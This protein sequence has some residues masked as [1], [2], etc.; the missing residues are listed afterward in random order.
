MT[1]RQTARRCLNYLPMVRNWWSTARASSV[2]ATACML[3][4]RGM[5]LGA[6]SH[7]LY[8]WP[9]ARR[10]FA[11]MAQRVVDPFKVLGVPPTATRAEASQ[12]FRVKAMECHPDLNQDSREATEQMQAL[13]AAWGSVKAILG[14]VDTPGQPAQAATRTTAAERQQQQQRSADRAATSQR[15]AEMAAAAKRMAAERM[16]AERMAAERK[17]AER[18]AVD[19]AKF[20]EAKAK[21][22][23][24]QEKRKRSKTERAEGAKVA[25]AKRVRGAQ[26][27]KDAKA[28]EVADAAEAT[29]RAEHA[30]NA[31]LLAREEAVLIANASD[32]VQAK[33][34]AKRGWLAYY[35]HVSITRRLRKGALSRPALSVERAIGLNLIEALE[36]DGDSTI[37]GLAVIGAIHNGWRFTVTG[38]ISP[39]IELLAR[40]GA[41]GAIFTCYASVRVLYNDLTNPP[42]KPR[43]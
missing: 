3:A 12:A 35:A 19:R 5:L 9:G 11:K 23:V 6:C 7:R 42:S 25:R 30:V 26:A 20:K 2:A 27:A 32:D 15:A 31:E 40:S 17:A 21:D 39:S 22:R 34:A 10:T 29:R 24:A 14:R 37:I 8:N 28:K 4:P 36:D 41:L 16:A 38:I 13:T 43:R 1:V 33:V 18:K